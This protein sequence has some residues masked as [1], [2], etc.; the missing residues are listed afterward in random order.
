MDA[1]LVRKSMK[2]FNRNVYVGV[3]TELQNCPEGMVV[4]SK[5]WDNW[6]I[7]FGKELDS[8]LKRITKPL[9]GGK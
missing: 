6:L 5:D 9:T 2:I 3:M 7:Q 8:E 4:G 1:Y